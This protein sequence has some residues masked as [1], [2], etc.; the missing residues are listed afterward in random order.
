[1]YDGNPPRL[2]DPYDDDDD[3]PPEERAPGTGKASPD[4]PMPVPAR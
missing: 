1:V 4:Q 3:D 2:I